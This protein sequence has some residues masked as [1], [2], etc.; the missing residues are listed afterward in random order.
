MPVAVRRR[1]FEAD[2]RARD[3]RLPFFYLPTHDASTGFSVPDISAVA[4]LIPPSTRIDLRYRLIAQ[5]ISSI[6]APVPRTMRK[7]YD[8]VS[9]PFFFLPFSHYLPARSRFFSLRLSYLLAAVVCKYM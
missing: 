8:R 7:Y 9:S 1:K 6:R 5:R 3:N 2:R 4:I